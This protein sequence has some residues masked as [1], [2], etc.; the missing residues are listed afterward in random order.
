M[1]D[2]VA[3]ESANASQ[4]EGDADM[5]KKT[6]SCEP[7]KVFPVYRLTVLNGVKST[8]KSTDV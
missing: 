4:E 3:T 6:G 1:P 5:D 8:N 7:A 2:S